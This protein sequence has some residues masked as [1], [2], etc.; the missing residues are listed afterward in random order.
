MGK[1]TTHNQTDR[2]NK[3][4]IDGHAIFT[5][6]PLDLESIRYDRRLMRGEESAH[7]ETEDE[8][9]AKLRQHFA[10]RAPEEAMTAYRIQETIL[11]PAT[12]YEEYVEG[13]NGL[14]ASDKQPWDTPSNELTFN[15]DIADVAM[16]INEETGESVLICPEGASYARY[17][18]EGPRVAPERSGV[19]R[20]V[21][22]S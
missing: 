7:P 19:N 8:A 17:V 22:A 4:D 21:P 2:A 14:A 9:T 5:R 1:S 18:A 3:G 13:P 16:V 20:C 10:D 15:G 12:E 6:K 11:L